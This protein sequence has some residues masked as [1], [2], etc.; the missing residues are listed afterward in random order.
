[1][2]T[3]TRATSGRKGAARALTWA[4]ALIC[5]AGCATRQVLNPSSTLPPDKAVDALAKRDRS[6]TSLQT[7][8]IMD[9]SGPSGHLKAREELTARRPASLRVDAV[10]PLG[11]ALIV[12]AG[13]A[14]I[15]VFNPSNNTLMR[16]A[17]NAT[18]LARFTRIP[19]APAQAVP[20]L[21]GLVPDNSILAAIPS[22][23]WTDGEMRILSYTRTGA[24][25]Y[26]LGFR[27]GQLALVRA[28]DASG[29]V[30]YEVY[31]G[32]YRDIGAMKFPFELDARFFATATTLKLHYLNPLI[33]RQITDSTFVLSPGPDT[34]LI[35]LGFA[36]P[37]MLQAGPG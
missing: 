20:L 24:A 5:V 28:R 12:V 25:N 18:T 31:Y 21:L 11:V 29:Q 35:E 16:G 32:D 2:S 33:D 34:R 27:D 15:A 7:P 36:A 22:K 26:E 13:D 4:L 23:S 9:Y 8:L 14:Q 37:S 17:A 19:L 1:M 6:L 10:S 3:N 30:N